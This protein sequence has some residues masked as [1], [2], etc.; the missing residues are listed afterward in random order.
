M[1]GRVPSGRRARHDVEARRAD[2]LLFHSRVLRTTARRLS[3]LFMH[4]PRAYSVYVVSGASEG[5]RALESI[6]MLDL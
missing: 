5:R 4:P 1:T 2:E 3:S 6:Q